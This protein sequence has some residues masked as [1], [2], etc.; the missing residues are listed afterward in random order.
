MEAG[1]SLVVVRAVLTDVR[2]VF[3][4]ELFTD[5]RDQFF[6]TFFTNG[7]IREVGVAATAIPVAFD[8]L[9]VQRDP[10]SVGFGGPVQEVA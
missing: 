10:D 5:R 7:G 8:R 1:Q 3:G 9:G 4:L 2:I 6:S